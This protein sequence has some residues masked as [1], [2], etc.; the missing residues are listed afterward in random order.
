MRD[1]SV[2]IDS[3]KDYSLQKKQQGLHRKRELIDA[4]LLN[5]SSNDYLSL[6]TDSRIKKSYQTGF[7]RYP[8]GSGGS[9]LVSGYHSAHQALEQGFAQALDVDA[10][11][12]FSSGFTANLSVINLLACVNAHV[13]LDKAA[14]ASIYDGLALSG[15]SYSRFLHNDLANLA[16]KMQACPEQSVVMTESLF[17]MSGQIAPL[18]A[19]VDLARPYGFELLVD[20][21]HAFGVLGREGLG[22]VI[23]Q[24]LMQEDVPL[25]VIPLGK[26]FGASGAVVA[27]QGVWIDALLQAAR[28]YIYST[29]ISPAVAFGL[30]ETLDIIRSADLRRTK[31]TLLVNYFRENIKKSSLTWRDSHTPIQQVQLGCPHRALAC[32]AFLREQGIVCIPMRQPT[33]SLQETGL[34]VILNYHHTQEEID[35]LFACLNVLRHPE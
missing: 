25:R 2:L 30:L 26:A 5:F 12:V 18:A 28:A 23:E 19:M 21:A 1:S 31:L 3:L 35:H 14:H 11:I 4:G 9:M 10:C 33:V 8:V 15:V 13:L 32:A 6:A 17:S 16:L 34:R 24:G 22:A 27:G 7:T 20:E 29:A